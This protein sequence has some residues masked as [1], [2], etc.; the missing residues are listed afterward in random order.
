MGE[1]PLQFRCQQLVTPVEGRPQAAVPLIRVAAAAGEQLEA[2]VQPGE[3][4]CRGQHP[5]PSRSQLQGQRQPLQPLAQRR[6]GRG[7]PRRHLEV[8][9]HRLRPVDEE[10]NAGA[11]DEG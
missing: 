10:A 11:G 2:L 7:I 4:L 9:P 1:E 3:H 5:S 6:D 8:G